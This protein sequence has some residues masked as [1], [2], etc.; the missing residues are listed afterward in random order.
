MMTM[1]RVELFSGMLGRSPEIFQHLQCGQA[2]GRAHYSTAGMRGRAA[3]VQILDG[4]AEARVAR[5]GTQE[6]KLFERKLALENV[7]LAQSPLA[8]EVKRG[9]DLP[10]KNDVFNIRRVLS[11]GV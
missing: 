1:S 9:N 11:D 10:V 2:S 3:H 5:R 8:F 6:E 4:R 7:A